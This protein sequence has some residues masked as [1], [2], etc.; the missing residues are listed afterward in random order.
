[1]P[2]RMARFLIG[3]WLAL[4]AACT[5]QLAPTYDAELVTGLDEA[6][7]RALS[8]FAALDGGS[9]Q[10]AFEQHAMEYAAVIGSLDGLRQRAETRPLPPLAE[11][12]AQSRFFADFCSD[13]TACLSASPAS[14]G[15]ALD[16]MRMM[17]R[18]HRSSDLP[19][20]EVDLFKRDYETAI[21]QSLFVEQ[22]LER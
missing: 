9:P 14:L 4:L 7:I 11:R 13:P 15:R 20:D 19:G 3:I 6:N 8:L 5:V 1:M 16:V 2:Q 21:K 12:L 10:T 17:R 18:R 22:A